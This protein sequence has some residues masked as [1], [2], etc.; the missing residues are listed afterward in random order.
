MGRSIEVTATDAAY[1]SPCKLL[2]VIVK[3]SG[4]TGSF[5]VRDGDAA[6]RIVASDGYVPAS[7]QSYFLEVDHDCQT[8]LHV[9][10]ANCTIYCVIR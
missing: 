3:P 7:G 2:R 8:A 1:S 6:G 5:T 10:I 9:T 4:I